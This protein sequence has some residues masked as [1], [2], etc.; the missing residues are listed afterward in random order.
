VLGS[1]SKAIS[2]QSLGAPEQQLE[3]APRAG[4]FSL[5]QRDALQAGSSC[6]TASPQIFAARWG[7]GTAQGLRGLSA[8][9]FS[10]ASTA[11][12]VLRLI[13]CRCDGN[14]T[15]CGLIHVTDRLG[16]G[17]VCPRRHGVI[18][19]LWASFGTLR[20]RDPFPGQGI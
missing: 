10:L 14:E 12:G 19:K 7:C 3:D 17:L 15:R 18:P 6:S 9:D 16:E 1:R 2:Q 4:P 8:F 13:L 11:R 5:C 20:S